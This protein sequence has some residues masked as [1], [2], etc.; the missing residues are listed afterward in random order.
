LYDKDKSFFDHIVSV[1]PNP[2]TDH[3]TVESNS[4]S[5]EA[6]IVRII[7]CLGRQVYLEYFPPNNEIKIGIKKLGLMDGNYILQLSNEKE[8]L[9]SEIII[10][11]SSY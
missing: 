2:S 4:Q 6:Q 8:L 5:S 3:I 1:Y 7:D 11:K 10:V 9:H